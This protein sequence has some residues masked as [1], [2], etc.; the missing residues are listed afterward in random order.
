MILYWLSLISVENM[1]MEKKKTADE[2][3]SNLL[4]ELHMMQAEAKPQQPMRTSQQFVGA[5]QPL[6]LKDHR[7]SFHV[8]ERL[9]MNVESCLLNQSWMLYEQLMT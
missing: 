9:V 5:P 1:L 8:Y 4:K 7:R 6:I 3:N 2:S